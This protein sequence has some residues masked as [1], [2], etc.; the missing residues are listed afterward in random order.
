MK[1]SDRLSIALYDPMTDFRLYQQSVDALFRMIIKAVGSKFDIIMASE[2]KG[3]PLAFGV[4]E[5]MA[6][7]RYSRSVQVAICRKSLKPYFKHV[8][9]A[10]VNTVTTEGEQFIYL[11]DAHQRLAGKRVVIVDDV[12]STGSSL[13]AMKHLISQSSGSFVLAASVLAEDKG[14]EIEGLHYLDSIPVFP[15]ME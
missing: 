9:S 6:R 13:K 15:K 5:R 12:V 14:T 4:A 1:V 3:I 2:A 10:K 7:Y 11:A 8:V